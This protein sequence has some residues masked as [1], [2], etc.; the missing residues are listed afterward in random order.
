MNVTNKEDHDGINSVE[1]E[2]NT[3]KMKTAN[4]NFKNSFFHE[5]F[6]VSE[7]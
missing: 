7:I 5:E 1:D 2:A 4:F 3:E 6:K